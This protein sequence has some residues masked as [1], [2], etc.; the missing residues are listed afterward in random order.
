MVFGFI[1]FAVIVVGAG[2][3]FLAAQVSIALAIVVAVV[4]VIGTLLLGVYQAA[5]SGV[6]SAALYRYAT[7]GE[8]PAGF[9]SLQLEHAFAP[10]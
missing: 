10:K 2:L 9:E 3:A 8:A 4:F 1:T 6:Y 5:L 7:H